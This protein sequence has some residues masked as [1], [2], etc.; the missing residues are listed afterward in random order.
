M[1]TK[2]IIFFLI[3]FFVQIYQSNSSEVKIVYKVN[4]EILTNIDIANEGKY[5]LIVNTNL[6]NLNKNELYELS[7][8]SLI[9]QILKKEEVGSL[10]HNITAVKVVLLLGTKQFTLR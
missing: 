4:N 7:K 3:I 8:N 6:K 9:R 1:I 5:L 2:K 10:S